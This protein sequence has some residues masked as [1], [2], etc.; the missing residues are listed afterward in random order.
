MAPLGIL[1]A[2]GAA[3]AWCG[4]SELFVHAVPGTRFVALRHCPATSDPSSDITTAEP[5]GRFYAQHTGPVTALAVAT[6]KEG[7]DVIA[8]AASDDAAVHIWVAAALTPLR[9]LAPTNTPDAAETSGAG[10]AGLTGTSSANGARIDHVAFS[11]GGGR[12]LALETHSHTLRLVL[13]RWAEAECVAILDA[14]D[15][16]RQISFAGFVPPADGLESHRA[17]WQVYAAAGHRL[18]VWAV[19][20]TGSGGGARV[21]A[22]FSHPS[23][24]PIQHAGRACMTLPEE[25][26]AITP[27]LLSATYFGASSSTAPT[28]GASHSGAA[29][30]GASGSRAS[31]FRS[32]TSGIIELSTSGHQP[33]GG[34]GTGTGGGG[35]GGAYLAIGGAN[36]SLWRVDA[37]SLLRAARASAAG[38][39]GGPAGGARAF[40]KGGSRARALRRASRR[41]AGPDSV[42]NTTGGA[43]TPGD[44]P[45]ADAGFVPPA[46]ATG[47]DPTP[48]T[49]CDTSDCWRD[50]VRLAHAGAVS[51]LACRP[52]IHTCLASGGADGRIRLWTAELHPMLT[53]NLGAF[54]A[55]ALDPAGRQPRAGGGVWPPHPRVLFWVAPAGEEGAPS[56]LQPSAMGFAG[57]CGQRPLEARFENGSG[58]GSAS[59]AGEGS[60]AMIGASRGPIMIPK[61]GSGGQLLACSGGEAVVLDI[62]TGKWGILSQG[63]DPFTPS[64]QAAAIALPP[65]ARALPATFDRGLPVHVGHLSPPLL[66]AS[67]RGPLLASAAAD[68]TVRVWHTGSRHQLAARPIAAAPTALTWSA[69]GDHLFIAT[70][71]G[72]L[73][74]LRARDLQVVSQ[75]TL[76]PVSGGADFATVLAAAP[77]GGAVVAIGTSRGSLLISTPGLALRACSLPPGGLAA[78]TACGGGK[79]GGG[80]GDGGGGKEALG[81]GEGGAGSSGTWASVGCGARGVV[82]SSGRGG[83]T[84]GWGGKGVGDRGVAGG[85]DAPDAMA[86]IVAVDWSL[87]G[88]TVRAAAAMAGGGLSLGAWRARDGVREMTATCGAEREEWSA[89]AWQGAAGAGRVGASTCG[90]AAGAAADAQAA[91]AASAG[92]SRARAESARAADAA[93][94]S[95]LSC[96]GAWA[97]DDV[98]AQMDVAGAARLQHGAR[99]VQA[100]RLPAT[101]G[102]LSSGL[103]GILGGRGDSATRSL[104]ALLCSDG[105]LLLLPCLASQPLSTAAIASALFPHSSASTLGRI[106]LGSDSSVARARI[107]LA[108]DASL[109]FS[110]HTGGAILMH[111]VQPPPPPPLPLPPAL[112][113]PPDYYAIALGAPPAPPPLDLFDQISAAGGRQLLSSCHMKTFVPAGLDP[114]VYAAPAEAWEAAEEALEMFGPPP[115]PAAVTGGSSEAVIALGAV[116]LVIA[117]SGGASGGSEGGGGATGPLRVYR[118]HTGT[119]CAIVCHP[120]A[121]IV[122]SAQGQ[123]DAAGG[124]VGGQIRLW[125]RTALTTLSVIGPNLCTPRVLAFDATGEALLAVLARGAGVTSEDGGEGTPGSYC[126]ASS[127]G[128]ASPDT[129]RDPEP[130]AGVSA[131]AIAVWAWRKSTR[132]A[133]I[134]PR[135]A[136][137]A[138]AG[139]PLGWAPVHERGLPA[140]ASC[141]VSES[142]SAPCVATAAHST[143]DGS[144]PGPSLASS[145]RLQ[146]LTC[147]PGTVRF[148]T[149]SR[150]PP[151]TAHTH[152]A[153]SSP[154]GCN[155][156]LAS[157][158]LPVDCRTVFLCAASAGGFGFAGSAA[159]DIYQFGSVGN[160]PHTLVRRFRAHRGPVCALAPISSPAAALGAAG[161]GATTSPTARP[162]DALASVLALAALGSAGGDGRI[163]LWS[164]GG[165][166]L[167]S[168]PLLPSLD[169]ARDDTGRP[170]PRGIAPLR[171]LGL[172]SI[173][174]GSIV[175]TVGR[176]VLRVSVLAGE[177]LVGRAFTP[178]RASVSTSAPSWVE[179]A[180]SSESGGAGTEEELL[181]PPEVAAGGAVGARVREAEMRLLFHASGAIPRRA[182][183]HVLAWRGL[184]LAAA[185]IQVDPG[186]RTGGTAVTAFCLRPWRDEPAMAEATVERALAVD[187]RAAGCT[188]TTV[189]RS[190][191]LTWSRPPAVR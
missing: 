127:G 88:R 108:P 82:V 151:P 160:R 40:P 94:T 76:P 105:S 52:H 109:L 157:D 35:G 179:H 3:P 161:N 177:P 59:H 39:V 173:S 58:C 53:L 31:N 120:T 69:S 75:L 83:E 128:V 138:A 36:G 63:H 4:E 50:R 78:A 13:W 8:S 86:P 26:T 16:P 62:S 34:G 110:S 49:L 1:G 135:P 188:R 107:A 95:V 90:A 89:P 68:L 99:V 12:L 148:W 112:P 124:G 169:S 191:G 11:H 181:H 97:S 87:D 176:S 19:D 141:F 172:D 71:D 92:R 137:G 101:A 2:G 9:V 67:P 185:S 56:H 165:A 51:C 81:W 18:A 96:S 10:K 41:S 167:C 131:D 66:A 85:S 118:A 32:S 33:G 64:A 119:I 190:P 42:D 20:Q 140:F 104:A 114:R 106:Q 156:H 123:A 147:G 17:P 143:W 23:S 153:S 43:A 61:K 184:P 163:R 27:I 14:P 24:G 80:W 102:G 44:V 149:L 175:A 126:G 136:Q 180:E 117:T 186:L 132:D 152:A 54:A 30:S 73:V 74:W 25:A 84:V 15:L 133:V 46:T 116:A 111:P 162:G 130:G 189:V 100:A 93:V 98:T 164:S 139:A 150:S 28:F 79:G 57:A 121:A 60:G 29:C 122:A 187:G 55:A 6:T 178:R 129:A 182:E 48:V 145:G 38:G 171:I 7:L 47:V 113:P 5:D 154:Q 174:D 77:S 70:I 65:P 168:L 115:P 45:F 91:A 125:S 155:L 21:H 144:P 142:L 103:A 166:S 22:S 158:P 37:E 183:V 146:L 159:G 72:G 170:L 134:A